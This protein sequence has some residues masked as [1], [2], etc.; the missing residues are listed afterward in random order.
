[1]V[2][3]R[4][5]GAGAMLLAVPGPFF[6]AVVAVL[7]TAGA[8]NSS[9]IVDEARFHEQEKEPVI[10]VLEI[11]AGAPSTGVDLTE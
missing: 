10:E 9:R 3:S 8:V 1:M 5:T 4:R 7:V 11:Q 6:I 2:H